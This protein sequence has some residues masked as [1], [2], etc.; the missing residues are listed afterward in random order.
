MSIL[1]YLQDDNDHYDDPHHHHGNHHDY[2]RQHVLYAR[3][4]GLSS[5]LSKKSI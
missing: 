5:R 3:N 4:D 2:E 1:I